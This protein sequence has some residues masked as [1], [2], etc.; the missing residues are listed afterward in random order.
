M[1]YTFHL[2]IALATNISKNRS[3]PKPKGMMKVL[4]L[5]R[6]QRT[7]F[8]LKTIPSR[9]KKKEDLRESVLQV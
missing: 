2:A 4:M 6:A 8:P 5:A 3:N 1:A 7:R 9:K